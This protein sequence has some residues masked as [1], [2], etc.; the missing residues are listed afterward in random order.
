MVGWVSLRT[1]H[2]NKSHDA[3]GMAPSGIKTAASFPVGWVSLRTHHK[4]K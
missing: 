1:H 4:T 3:G 2:K